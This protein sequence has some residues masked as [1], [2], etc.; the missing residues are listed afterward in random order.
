MIEAL[1]SSKTRIKLL[2]K[3]F[4][5]SNTT[6][7]L[8]GLEGEFG[9]SSNAIRIEINRFE[10]AGLLSSELIGNKKM[11]QA[12]ITHP[13]FRE[14]HNILL[15]HVGIDH[16]LEQVINRLGAV[17]KVYLIG[18]FSKGMDSN[19]IDLIVVGD[20]DKAYLINLIE[21]AEKLMLRKIR[22]VIYQTQE[23]L[24]VD[25]KRFDPAPLLIW[26]KD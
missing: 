15:K 8:R 3:F 6:A 10:Q 19:I 16:V 20:I 9:E 1:I 22:Y 17:E 26:S 12:N 7:Y 25:W 13:L 21:K 18:D 4:L 11:F 23:M 24:N 2:L 14:I 5:N